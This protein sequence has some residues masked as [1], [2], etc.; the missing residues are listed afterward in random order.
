MQPNTCRDDDNC[1]AVAHQTVDV[2]L[3]VS[4]MPLANVGNVKAICCGEPHV[5]CCSMAEGGFA[6]KITQTVTYKIPISY[7]ASFS[8]GDVSTGCNKNC[9]CQSCQRRF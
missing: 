5:E 2:A 6:L 3:P 7:G 8:T 1:F 4:I 9:S